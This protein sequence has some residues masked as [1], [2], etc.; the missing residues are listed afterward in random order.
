MRKVIMLMTFVCVSVMAWG[1]TTEGLK[2]LHEAE[3][4][5]CYAQFSI[6]LFY[7]NGDEGFPKNE[8]K[9]LSW[10]KK[11]AENNHPMACNLL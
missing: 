9:S 10:F 4:G 5:N 6:G 7:Q 2:I 1:Q 11:A 3:A 8:F